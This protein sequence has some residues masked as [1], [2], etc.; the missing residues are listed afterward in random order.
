MTSSAR[1]L[2]LAAVLLTGCDRFWV[3]D[4]AEPERVAELPSR[5]SETGLYADIASGE[6]ADG[7]LA[8]T[9]RFPLWSD[10]ADKQ[11]WILL[12]DGAQIDTSS[13][14]E[15]SFP[16]GTKVWKEFSV[17]G[18][19]IETRLI[20]KRG[21]SDED[22]VALSYVWSADDR[23]AIAAPLGEL[24]ARETEHDVPGAGECVACHGGRRS[25][26]L[27]FSAI[28]LSSAAAP[29]DV[30]LSALA[31]EGRLTAPP[32]AVP[33]VPGTPVEVAALGYLHANCS[34]CHNPNRPARDGPRCFDPQTSY[35]FT[36]AIG[37]LASPANTATYRTVVG[38]AVKPGEPG[39]SR[40][41]SF[42]SRR[43]FGRQMPPLATNTVDSE[44]VANIRAWIEALR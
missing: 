36:L 24:D 37:D 39:D 44:A 35:D 29:G 8:Y 19:R 38:S 14:D 30:D 43:G 41:L 10:G 42:M 40:V 18:V 23:D 1:V 21:P 31:E 5:L 22:W 7:V 17:D 3:C 26:V 13:I 9:P 20:E 27:G 16:D 4:L 2:A 6:L 34:H 11:R 12:P 28:Q 32:A 15:W 25:Y 33:V